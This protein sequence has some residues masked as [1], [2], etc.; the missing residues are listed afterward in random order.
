MK[1][2][3]MCNEQ[4]LIAAHGIIE[5]KGEDYFQSFAGGPPGPNPK[6]EVPFEVEIKK[7]DHYLFQIAGPTSLLVLERATGESLRDIRFLHFRDSSINGIRT[8]VARIGM[9][10]NLAYELHGPIEEGPA[11]YDAVYQAGQ[12]LGIERLGWST[13]LVNT[14]RP[15]SRRERGRLFQP[16]LSGGGRK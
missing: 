7:L 8:E 14:S 9:S 16:L 5:R 4:G 3:V 13:Y 6:T 2:A 15:A 11:I 10:G 1:H 12:E